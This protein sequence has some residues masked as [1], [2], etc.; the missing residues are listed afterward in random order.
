MISEKSYIRS[1]IN[2]IACGESGAQWDGKGD[3]IG[4]NDCW[5]WGRPTDYLMVLDNPERFSDPRKQ[6]ILNSKPHHFITGQYGWWKHFSK[7]D[8][9]KQKLAYQEVH[10]TNGPQ[11]ISYRF[12]RW[13][14]TLKN[15]RIHYSST[16]PM[17]AI[18][19]AYLLG[20]K[21]IILWG[22][23]FNT[24]KKWNYHTTQGRE[25]I[26]IYRDLFRQ[27]KEMGVNVLNQ[28]ESAI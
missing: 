18:T 15:D 20:Y 14:G 28:P 13:T 2:V 9:P 26:A 21:E 4:V 16:S 17:C 5:K 22:V 11:V 23:D 8:M 19:L 3:S 7:S 24:H 1:V 10:C 25:E 27:L 6:I 12:S